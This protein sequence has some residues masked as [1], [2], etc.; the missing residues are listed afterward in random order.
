MF[1]NHHIQEGIIQRS[2]AKTVA[3]SLYT[4][5]K[6]SITSAF[7]RNWHENKRPGYG[8]LSTISKT[9]ISQLFKSKTF[10]ITS[11]GHESKDYDMLESVSDG[12]NNIDR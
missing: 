7:L 4:V 10:E 12:Q 5:E 2:T 11:N 6:T 8:R 9:D 1:T 3:V